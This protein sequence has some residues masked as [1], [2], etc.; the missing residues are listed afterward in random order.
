MT[1]GL[2][3]ILVVAVAVAVALV[4]VKG[5]FY[6]ELRLVVGTRFVEALNLRLQ[7]TPLPLVEADL[8]L[9]MGFF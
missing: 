4:I 2:K 5:I 6:C 1:V 7:K 3:I 9:L 8:V